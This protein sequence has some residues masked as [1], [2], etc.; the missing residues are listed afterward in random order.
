MLSKKDIAE[1]VVVPRQTIKKA[2]N[3]NFG[4]NLFFI[5]VS[6][7][8]NLPKTFKWLVYILFCRLLF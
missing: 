7:W 6:I 5:T 8:H 2:Q 3:I 1:S 4:L